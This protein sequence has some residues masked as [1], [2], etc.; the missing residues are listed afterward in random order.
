[1][2][3]VTSNSTLSVYHPTFERSPGF[4]EFYYDTFRVTVPISGI[5]TFISAASFDAYGL[6]YYPT[7]DRT[8]SFSNLIASD[9]NYGNGGRFR[10]QHRLQSDLQ[11]DLVFTSYWAGVT[12]DYVITIKGPAIPDIT[13]TISKLRH[14]SYRHP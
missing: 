13:R 9:G 4:G 6:L 12:G 1:M 2:P 10:F 8:S 7:F 14:T 5:Y 3:N 11:Y